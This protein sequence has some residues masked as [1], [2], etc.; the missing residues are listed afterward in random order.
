[1]AARR[2]WCAMRGP[3]RGGSIFPRKAGRETG[4]AL[5][6]S[7]CSNYSPLCD[8]RSSACRR[9]AGSPRR[10]G[11]CRR[12]T[13]PRLASR[14]RQRR[15]LCCRI[16]PTRPVP[17][18]APSPRSPSGP[19][20]RGGRRCSRHCRRP[21]PARNGAVLVYAPGNG[22]TNGRSA[23]RRHPPATIRSALT[24]RA[25]ASRH[26]LAKMP[27]R[28]RSRPI[29]P[30]P[31]PQRLRR[32]SGRTSR[33]PCSRRPAPGSARP[34]AISRRRASGPNAIK[35]RCGSRP[36][37]ATCRARSPANSTGSTPTRCRSAAAS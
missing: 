4:P 8:R 10:S 23:P 29:T 9:R 30:P 20:G 28:G 1:M 35:A 13:W 18:F 26:C 15:A 3:S 7:T 36:S 22:S 27:S 34:W 37:P 17:T 16:S 11:S 25:T 31:S 12:R 14:S 2:R 6:R 33:R 5:P 32:G 19:A 24:R 21:R